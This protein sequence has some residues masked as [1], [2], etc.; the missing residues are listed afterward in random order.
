MLNAQNFWVFSFDVIN[1]QWTV[2]NV[3]LRGKREIEPTPSW[4]QQLSYNTSPLSCVCLSAPAI[5]SY[6]QLLDISMQIPGISQCQ[7]C[8][9]PVPLRSF[10]LVFSWLAPVW[11]ARYP[12]IQDRGLSPSF[13][14]SAAMLEI[15]FGDVLKFYNCVITVRIQQQVHSLSLSKL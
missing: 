14:T 7:W 2:E 10:A 6:Y 3:G 11:S 9:A 13:P 4:V 8:L 5:L 12:I 1:M 15:M